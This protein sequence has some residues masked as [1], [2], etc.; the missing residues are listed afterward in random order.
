VSYVRTGTKHSGR[1]WELDQPIYKTKNQTE[2]ICY[3][4]TNQTLQPLNEN[5][6]E[7][8]GQCQDFQ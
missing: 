7:I 8:W 4:L 1:F 2:E 6:R 5:P 3:F